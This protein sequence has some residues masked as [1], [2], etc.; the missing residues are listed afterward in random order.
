M[1]LQRKAASLFIVWH[2]T[3]I[4]VTSLPTAKAVPQAAGAEG[5]TL[6]GV[7]RTLDLVGGVIAGAT[8]R[9]AGFARSLVGRPVQIYIAVTGQVQEWAMF[10][11]PPRVD[12]YWRVRYYIQP[13]D[14]RPWVATELVGPAHRDDRLRLLGSFRASYQDKA[15]ELALE[16]FLRRRKPA[17]VVPTAR[18][19]DLPDALAPIARLFARRFTNSKLV[20]SEQKIV[21]TEVWVARVDNK[22]PGTPIDRQALAERQAALLE[23]AEGPAENRLRAPDY[24]PYHGVEENAGVRWVLEYFEE[25]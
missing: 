5:R 25:S 21:R 1:T 23:Y 19:R 18:P 16:E 7:E 17:A 11:N 24:P 10:S 2:L 22:A 15:F 9:V 20:G 8:G 12:T 14:G 3:A 4:T 13:K 6:L